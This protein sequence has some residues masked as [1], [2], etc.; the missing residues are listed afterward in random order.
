M[1]LGG[2][3]KL[4]LDE[5]NR[6]GVEDF[7]QK[8]KNPITVVLDNVRSGLN[9]GSLFRTCDA[10]AIERII[11]LGITP[12]P[13]H[14]EILKSAIGATESVEWLHIPTV[15]EFEKYLI[16][17]KL[18]VIAVEQTDKSVQLQEA[19]FQVPYAL[20]FGNEVDGVS[21][22]VLS[23]CKGAVEIPQF[24]TK[25]SF[26]ISVSAG[27]VLWELLRKTIKTK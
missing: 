17:Q 16:E 5:L 22:E 23:L 21:D 14:R 8:E 15:E 20:V 6:D 27:I 19:N 13:P 2:F 24:G 9:V 11:L 7:K 10:L 18:E 25:H 26:N 1:A 4:K 3:K 12:Q